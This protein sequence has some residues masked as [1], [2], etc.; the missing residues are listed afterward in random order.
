MVADKLGVRVMRADVG[1]RD[2]VHGVLRF[3][4]DHPCD[5][6]VL[7]THAREGLP[8][9][10]R[11]SV[12]EPLS[13]KAR[14]P[15]LFLPHASPGFVSA[16]NG[17]VLLRSVLIPIDHSPS[18]SPA[19]SLAIKLADR[20]EAWETV[21]YLLHVGPDGP[22]MHV[23]ARY[24]PRLYHLQREGSVVDTIIDAADELGADLIV[25]AR[26][27]HEGFLDAFRGSTTEQVLRRA[28]RAML[29]A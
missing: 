22:T 3:L 19:V 13:R 21:Y 16:E 6:I 1:A 25:M 17:E 10:L 9:W 14:L 5:L 20:L 4:D 23:E 2:P 26:R 29:A 18:A 12:A 7:A 27:G 24:E 8:R 11:A 28:G 15:A